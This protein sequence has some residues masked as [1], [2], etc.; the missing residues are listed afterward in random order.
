MDEVVATLI[1]VGVGALV[2]LAAGV[3]VP[4]WLQSRE[5]RKSDSR[6]LRGEFRT[7]FAKYLEASINAQDK[8]TLLELSKRTI[9]PDHPEATDPRTARLRHADASIRFN[10]VYERLALTLTQ[11]D[12][13][14]RHV[15]K[16]A[17]NPTLTS[18]QM[19]IVLHHCASVVGDWYRGELNPFEARS[20]FTSSVRHDGLNLP[21]EWWLSKAERTR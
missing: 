7:E 8:K 17:T 11:D 3:F 1:G 19:A 10:F 5:Q 18:E 13:P 9:F 6:E 20:K 12:R 4:P 21:D 2:S 15:L 16:V 14:I